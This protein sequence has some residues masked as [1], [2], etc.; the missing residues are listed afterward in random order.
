LPTGQVD[1]VLGH[2]PHRVGVQAFG[3]VTANAVRGLVLGAG[4]LPAGHTVAGEVGMS[5]LWAT[6]ITLACTPLAV[7]AYRR[8]V[9]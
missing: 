4:A 7:R 1:A 6:G 9:A 5:L 2:R 3:V 8:T